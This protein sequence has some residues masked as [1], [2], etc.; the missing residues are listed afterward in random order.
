MSCP[1]NCDTTKLSRHLLTSRANFGRLAHL[2]DPASRYPVSIRRSRLP[3]AMFCPECRAEYRAGFTHCSD[4]DVDLVESLPESD[5][6]PDSNELDPEFKEV[7]S[8][9]KQDDCVSI[10]SELREAKIPF[11]VLQ[12][13]SQFFKDVD[14]DF[15]IGVP[16]EFF[17][18]AKELIA[19]DDGSQTGFQDDDEMQKAME[20]PVEDEVGATE[21]APRNSR[22]GKWFP[23]EATVEVWSEDTLNQT[24]MIEAC[25]TENSIHSRTDVLENGA[26][27]IFVRPED[28]AQAREIVHEV[29]DGVPPN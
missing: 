13:R 14:L 3:P 22:A 9:D 26:Q 23:E 12:G 7:W 8:G 28:E 15:K 6:K 1:H 2:M 29:V 4:C 24:S 16:A 20:L 5:G 10:C 18:R 25:L 19:K 11:H 21:N 27:K 17:D